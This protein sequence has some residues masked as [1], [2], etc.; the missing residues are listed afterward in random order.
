MSEEL[1]LVAIILGSA[2]DKPVAKK[3]TDLLKQLGVPYEAKVRSAHRTS[4]ELRRYLQECG[5]NRPDLR[6]F[7]CIAGK[8][9]ALPGAVVA[10]VR[11]TDLVIGVSVGGT[12]LEDTLAAELS[13]RQL[14][15]GVPLAY[16]GM[17]SAGATNAA[18][19]AARFVAQADKHSP[20]RKALRGYSESQAQAT[21]DSEPEVIEYLEAEG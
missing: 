14:P 13:M 5:H 20:I 12:T 3:C 7:I 18:L 16:T 21:I 6:V 4:H 9:A 1:P 17:D 8:A 19:I 10:E 2:S 15:G 11:A